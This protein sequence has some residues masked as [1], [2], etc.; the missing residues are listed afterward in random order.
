MD[1]CGCSVCVLL[2]ERGLDLSVLY[3]TTGVEG[4]LLLSKSKLSMPMDRRRE[5]RKAIKGEG[6]FLREIESSPANRIQQSLD[7]SLC[8][9][10]NA[11]AA[12]SG[13]WLTVYNTCTAP[14]Y[15]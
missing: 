1:I 11:V 14:L 2:G 7:T 10:T 3:C 5:N 13:K 12:I 15:S 9:A 6:E 4:P 8:S